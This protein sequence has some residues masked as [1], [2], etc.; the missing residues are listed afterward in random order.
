MSNFTHLHVHSQYS[1][2]DGATKIPALIK[3]VKELGMNSIALTDHGVMYGIKKFYNTA[4]AEGIKPI[5]GIETYIAPTSRHIKKSEKG[6]K[7]SYHLILL[8]K[9]FEGYKN[10]TKLASI[11]SIEGFYYKPRIDK[12]VL[13]QYSKGL[14][15][16]SACLGG[17][18]AQHIINGDIQNAID[19][20]KWY[21]NLFGEDYYIELM[22]HPPSEF[23]PNSA[24][25]NLQKQV[26]EKLKEI[27]KQLEIKCIATNDIHFLKKSDAYAHNVLITLNTKSTD[28]DE[29]SL[30]Y[31]GQEYLKSPEEMLE[32]FADFP[33]AVYNTQEIA[34]KVEDYNI[35][36]SPIMPVFK[37]PEPFTDDF[38]YL[39]HLTYEGAKKRW[40]E[41]FEKNDE[42]KQRV[43]FELET[44]RKMGFPSYFLIVADFIEQARKMGVSVGPGRGSAAGSAVAYC[45]KI[46]NIDPIKYDLLFE[47]FLNPDR[48]SMPDIDIDFDDDGRARVLDW[49]AQKYGEKRVAHIITFGTMATRSAIRDVA[50]VLN[51]PLSEADRIAKLI[52][53][54]AKSFKNAYELSPELAKIKADATGELAKLFEYAETLEGTIRQV[55]VHACG[56]IIGRDDLENFIPLTKHKEAKLYVTQYD[57]AFVEEVGLLKM[58]FLGLA[59]LSIINN[60]LHLIKINKGIEFDIDEISL[61]DPKVFEIFAQANTTGI[62]Q[63]ES[64]GMK[65]YLKALKPSKFEDIIAM[66]ALYRPGPMDYIEDFIERK[67]GLK[68]ITY[69]TPLMEEYLAK[70]YGITVYQE[71]VMLLSQK[72]AGFTK[73]EA[74]NLRKAMGKKKKDIIDKMKPKFIE[75]CANNNIDSTIAD[76]IWSDWE[77]FA[78]YAFNKSHSTCY[79]YLAYQ[80]AYLKTYYPAEFFAAL[81]SRNSGN[82]DDVALYI[83]DARK[84]GI[85]VLGPDI[86]ESFNSFSVNKKGQVRFGLTAIKGIGEGVVENIVKERQK[87]GNF[88]DIYDFLE[89]VNSGSINKRVLESLVLSGALDSISQ[90]QRHEY[91]SENNGNLTFID[92]LLKYSSN[93]HSD[94]KNS[95][96]SLFGGETEIKISKPKPF[97]SVAWS[98][99]E[100]L[101]K[102]KEVVGIYL[103]SHPLSQHLAV[104][105]ANTNTT[106]SQLANLQEFVNKDIK[107]AGIVTNVETKLSKNGSQYAFLTIEDFSGSFKFPLFSQQYITYKNFLEKNLKIFIVATVK[108]RK[109][110]INQ[111]EFNIKSINLLEN[112][113]IKNIALKIKI[114]QIN[115]DLINQLT[116][117]FE[118]NQGN[119]NVQVLIY[120]PETKTWIM[121]NSGKYKISVTN[122][123]L[124]YLKELNIE[125]KIS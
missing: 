100:K 47:R 102:E 38:Q 30:A 7:T 107:I 58:D 83:E 88:K 17:E 65:K 14:I 15:V 86:N 77:A 2:L 76:K 29:A 106:L 26:N 81:L 56:T 36:S 20:A 95:S 117:T 43:D 10:L 24:T 115:D 51:I 32:L 52:D 28:D 61:E 4:K 53:D 40:G 85:D 18:L 99:L 37:L 89:R 44:I 116:Q 120:E 94:K 11:A 59:T 31:S 108:N 41:E 46:T 21:K 92:V 27:A 13:Q 42:I 97:A 87:N 93:Y 22:L 74:D 125:T 124:N 45:L 62:F 121:M 123:V 25:Y 63:F 84:N 48:I 12:E 79:A 91:F 23:N 119:S 72:L 68:K 75:G 39:Q 71:Q 78:S 19:T 80:T 110:D 113:D 118:K 98:E 66:N 64:D 16:S 6:K 82:I 69:D 114:E 49:V 101:N 5:L 55:G 8:A 67:H 9:N 35:N 1:I 105:K 103:S 70:T 57:G 112:M 50:R 73:G 60:A 111:V 96:I 104:I 3:K 34:D 90:Y 54:K 122:E 33:E 109:D